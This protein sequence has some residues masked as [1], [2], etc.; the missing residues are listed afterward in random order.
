MKIAPIFD[1]MH[2][3]EIKLEVY[4]LNCIFKQECFERFSV[5]RIVIVQECLIELL[6]ISRGDR[7]HSCT[8]LQKNLICK[9]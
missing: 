3:S 2:F 1:T 4:A 9:G 6:H 5:C 8:G 7:K